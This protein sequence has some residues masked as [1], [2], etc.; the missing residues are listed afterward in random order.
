[1]RYAFNGHMGCFRKSFGRFDHWFG[2]LQQY[3]ISGVLDKMVE[4][5]RRSAKPKDKEAVYLILRKLVIR[6]KEREIDL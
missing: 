3:P 2:Q 6:E 5:L 1:M 4:M